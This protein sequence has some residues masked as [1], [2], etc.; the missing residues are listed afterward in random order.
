MSSLALRVA[1]FAARILPTGSRLAMYRLGPL[2]GWLRGWLN[3]SA[4]EGIAPVTVAAGDLAG[5]QLLLD[6]Q[7]DKDLWLG[8][9]EPKVARAL[10]DLARPSMTAYDLGANIGYMTLLLAKAVGEHGRVVAVEPLPANVDRLRSAVRLNGMEERVAVVPKAVG[11]SSR[12]ERF[13]I[14]RSPGMGRLEGAAGRAGGFEDSIEVDVVAMD[15]LVHTQGYPQPDLVKV[16]LEGGEGDALRGMKQI[17]RD[18]R[19]I[20]VIEIHGEAAADD[21]WN[22]LTSA[23]YTLQD[24]EHG[25]R[26]VVK[27]VDLRPKMYILAKAKGGRG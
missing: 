23:G 17:L 3:R 20:L 6:L 10:R 19:P 1:A 18:L 15:D 14:H 4:P 22:Q 8:T 16:D 12:R 24:L 7:V 9:Y 27:R 2:T 21:V 11:T 5:A 26:P 25:S 13:L